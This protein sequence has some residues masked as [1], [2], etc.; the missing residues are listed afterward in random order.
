MPLSPLDKEI[1][2]AVLARISELSFSFFASWPALSPWY[3]NRLL[4][5]GPDADP[6][7]AP[8]HNYFRVAGK[9]VLDYA[10]FKIS[11]GG[12]LGKGPGYFTAVEACLHSNDVLIAL[13]MQLDPKVVGTSLTKVDD[14]FCAF[15]GAQWEQCGQATERIVELLHPVFL[16]LAEAAEAAFT[17]CR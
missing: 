1:R 11:V 12:I 10:I 16:H 3:W 15:L 4:A 2:A 7:S 13:F 8:D 9:A 17:M 5:E 6:Q 14:A